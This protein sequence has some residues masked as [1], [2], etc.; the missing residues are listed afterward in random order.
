MKGAFFKECHNT[1]N[2]LCEMRYDNGYMLALIETKAMTLEEAKA[3]LKWGYNS[4]NGPFNDD[5]DAFQR[6]THHGWKLIVLAKSLHWAKTIGHHISKHVLPAAANLVTNRCKTKC[7]CF[8]GEA[9]TDMAHCKA[10]NLESCK[11]CNDGYELFPYGMKHIVVSDNVNVIM[12]LVQQ[13]T[14]ALHSMVLGH[15]LLSVSCDS[16]YYLNDKNQCIKCHEHG[17]TD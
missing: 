12:V 3:R 7:K 13:V 16:G 5:E 4:K 15:H 1:T 14:I 17:Q 11:S 9:G 8:Q 2:T 10:D 6:A